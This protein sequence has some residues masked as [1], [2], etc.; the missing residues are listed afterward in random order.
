MDLINSLDDERLKDQCN[1]DTD[2]SHHMDQRCCRE[3]LVVHS[4][5]AAL[6]WKQGAEICISALENRIKE[7]E[8]QF[9]EYAHNSQTKFDD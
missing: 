1:G 6:E 8:N 2:H 5:R 3:A 9:T 7:I 4:L